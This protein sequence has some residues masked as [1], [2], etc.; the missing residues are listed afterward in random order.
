MCKSAFYRTCTLIVAGGFLSAAAW[1]A[2]APFTSRSLPSAAQQLIRGGLCATTAGQ[3][4]VDTGQCNSGFACSGG[5][6]QCPQQGQGKPCGTVVLGY[7][8]EQCKQALGGECATGAQVR[9][10]DN[11]SCR[12]NNQGTMENPD[13]ECKNGPLTNLNKRGYCMQK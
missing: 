8:I 4:C 2:A 9:C 7:Y 12:C 1:G 6:G 5:V 11:V 10:Q 13:W 3:Q